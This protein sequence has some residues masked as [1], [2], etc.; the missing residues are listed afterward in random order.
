MTVVVIADYLSSGNIRRDIASPAK[1]IDKRMNVI[2]KKGKQL[3]QKLVFAACKIERRLYN[4]AFFFH[5][6]L[7]T[8]SLSSLSAYS[9]FPVVN[10]LNFSENIFTAPFD[11]NMSMISASEIR[12]FERSLPF[13]AILL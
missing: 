2:G 8:K 13:F 12:A 1:Q 4:T 5:V 7:Q 3:R 6:H 11:C 10:A 9:A